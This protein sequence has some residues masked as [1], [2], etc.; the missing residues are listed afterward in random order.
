MTENNHDAQPSKPEGKRVYVNL[1]FENWDSMTWQQ[2]M[3]FASNL[4][5]AIVEDLTNDDEAEEK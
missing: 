2:K 4:H 3:E 1:N 5:A